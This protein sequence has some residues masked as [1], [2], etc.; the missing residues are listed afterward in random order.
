VSGD[1]DLAVR[2]IVPR[3]WAEVAGAVLMEHLGAYA[4]ETVVPASGGGGVA[5]VFY[6]AA[7]ER[8]TDAGLL[9]LLP[10]TLRAEGVVRIE[11]RPVP[12]DWV[13]GW[14]DHF[15]PIVIGRVWVRPPWEPAAPAA[16][17]GGARGAAGAAAGGALVD[18]VINP[19]LGFGTGLHPTTRGT[20]TLLQEGHSPAQAVPGPRGALVDVGTG[21]GILCIAAAKLGWAPIISFDNDAVA[22]AAARDNLVQNGVAEVVE[23]HECAVAEA[24]ISWFSGVT[25]LANMTLEPVMALVRRLAD[26]RPSRLVVAGILAGIQ[27]QE[28]VG[29]AGRRGLKPGRRLYETEWVAMELFPAD[30]AGGGTSGA[31]A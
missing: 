19:G 18:V 30:T 24:P 10:E 17:A 11:R 1:T 6:P 14:R 8:L 28:F 9:A 3:P 12:R 16:G 2:V 31:E 22:L 21:S 23:L 25:V 5:L 15:H 27:E 4:E 7:A 20:L 29:E 13:E 26:A